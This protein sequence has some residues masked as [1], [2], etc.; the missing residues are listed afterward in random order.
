MTV[1][2]HFDWRSAASWHSTASRH[3]ACFTTNGSLVFR[4]PSNSMDAMPSTA[5]GQ[6]ELLVPR[7]NRVSDFA[8]KMMHPQ[9]PEKFKISDGPMFFSPQDKTVPTMLRN[10]VDALDKQ[11]DSPVYYRFSSPENRNVHGGWC[12]YT[13]CNKDGAIPPISSHEAYF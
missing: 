9:V 4:F 6:N 1:W 11:M 2:D 5:P 7:M 10:M 8:P 13:E 12:E 3:P